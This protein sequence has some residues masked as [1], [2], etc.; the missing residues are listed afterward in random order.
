MKKILLLTL[1]FWAFFFPG[2]GRSK[3][4]KD[5][6]YQIQKIIKY[7]EAKNFDKAKELLEIWL[8]KSPETFPIGGF[9]LLGNIYDQLKIFSAAVQVFE[10]GLSLAENKFPF[11]VN[12]AQ[13]Y[14]HMHNHQKAVELL[15]RVKSKAPLY[16]AIYLFLGMS[17]V[18]LRDRLKVIEYWERYLEFKPVGAK[19]DRVR[20]ALA[21]LKQKDFKWPEE[22]KKESQEKSEELKKFLED[23]KKTVKQENIKSLKQSSEVKEEKLKIKDKGKEEGE[24]FDEVE[25]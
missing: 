19:S 1:F 24:K 17:Y 14:R 3:K 2:N 15:T 21:W 4:T 22:L 9:L 8:S 7:Y 11:Y 13:V 18:H 23:L 10:K 12:L 16:P 25:R 20:K 6:P 5:S